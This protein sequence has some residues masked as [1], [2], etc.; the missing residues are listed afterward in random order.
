MVSMSAGVAGAT[1]IV[2][3]RIGADGSGITL[4]EFTNWEASVK[5][6][7]RASMAS[8]DLGQQKEPGD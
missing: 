8:I 4:M 2:P 3:V 5:W 1:S 7:G 6:F